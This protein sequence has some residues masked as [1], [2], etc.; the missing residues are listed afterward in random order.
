VFS[1]ECW[2][3]YAHGVLKNIGKYVVDTTSLIKSQ[4]RTVKGGLSGGAGGWL[5]ALAKIAPT[6]DF[7]ASSVYAIENPHELSLSDAGV[8]LVMASIGKGC[9]G[10]IANLEKRHIKV[11]LLTGAETVTKTTITQGK[12]GDLKFP[13]P[14][15]TPNASDETTT[16]YGAAAIAV[17]SRNVSTVKPQ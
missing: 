11:V 9:T 10:D 15:P 17:N 7:S 8:A 1:E 13:L 3:D 5:P 4:T 14:W 16:V 6:F 12:S 2:K